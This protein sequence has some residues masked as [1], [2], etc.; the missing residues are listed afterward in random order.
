V[1]NEGLGFIIQHR[2]TNR[3]RTRLLHVGINT[4]GGEKKKKTGFISPKYI[5]TVISEKIS[6]VI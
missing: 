3:R 4:L 1:E 6:F 2:R 5:K